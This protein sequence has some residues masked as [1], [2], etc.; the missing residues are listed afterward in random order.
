[1]P[2]LEK[3]R[4]VRFRSIQ[5]QLKKPVV[6]YSDFECVINNGK[7]EPCGYCLY[8]VSQ[9]IQLDFGMKQYRGESEDDTMKHYFD[10]LATFK[11]RIMKVVEVNFPMRFTNE[12]KNQIRKCI[13]LSYL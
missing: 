12:D 13:T 3:D 1:M 4:I 10:D 8:V 2:E 6:I 5:K 7:H 9:Y 11:K